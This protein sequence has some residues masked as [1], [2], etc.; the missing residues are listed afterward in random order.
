V[1]PAGRPAVRPC[2]PAAVLP[3]AVGNLGDS[4]MAARAGSLLL[5]LATVHREKGLGGVWFGALSRA[6]YRRL[7][8][9]ERRLDSP[10]AAAATRRQAVIRALDAGDE[11]AFV[12]LGQDTAATFHHRL[13]L[14]HRCWGAWCDDGLRHIAWIGFE[15]VTVD[16]LA[17]EVLLADAVSY[18]YQA[19]TQPQY[20]RLGLGP[21]AHSR[22]LESLRLHGVRLSL[23]AVLPDNPWAFG[24]WLA[25]GYRRTGTVRAIGPGPRPYVISTRADRAATPQW[26]FARRRRDEARGRRRT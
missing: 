17:C 2:A 10:I 22:C 4:R 9:L 24:P 25:V 15:R 14:G 19:Y 12:G 6:G 23:A 18:V 21:A 16:Y 8:V 7:V 11:A 26:R 3:S 5:R 20:R 13:A 1:F